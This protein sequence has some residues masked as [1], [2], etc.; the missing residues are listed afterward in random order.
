MA[1]IKKVTDGSFESQVLGSDKVFVLDLFSEWCQPCKVMSPVFEE[2]AVE[3]GDRVNFGKVDISDNPQIP[4]KY[5]V[6]S[7]PTFMIFK[8]GKEAKRMTGILPK[9]KFKA[10]IE[11]IL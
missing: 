11:E 4:G 6:M 7:I 5:G 1:D 8:D 3:L 10:A 9:G 2:L